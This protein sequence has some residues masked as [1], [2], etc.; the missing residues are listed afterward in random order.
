[1]AAMRYPPE[2]VRGVAGSTRATRF[3]RIKDYSKRAA[4][5]FCLIVQIETRE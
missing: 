5:E 4:S 2:G 3:G 1:M